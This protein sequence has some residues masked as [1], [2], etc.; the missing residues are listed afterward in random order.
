M[1]G[2]PEVTYL[3]VVISEFFKKIQSEF[4]ASVSSVSAD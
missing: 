1:I 2:L 3:L 4:F